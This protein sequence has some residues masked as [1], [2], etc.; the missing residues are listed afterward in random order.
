MPKISKEKI[1]KIS[2]QVLFYLFQIFPKQVF[3]SDIAAELARDEEFIKALLQ[4]LEKNQLV[5]RITKNSKG[6][7]YSRRLRWRLSNKAHE[8][9]SQQQKL[10]A[11]LPPQNPDDDV[12]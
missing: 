4:E 3:T 6:E 8:A 12:F 7:D 10:K 1:N 5:T 11:N 2:E 9:Y